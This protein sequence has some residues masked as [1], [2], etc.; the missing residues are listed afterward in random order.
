MDSID[1]I[2]QM[3]RE[4]YNKAADK[5]HILFHNEMNEKEYDRN[6]L[7][8]FSELLGPGASV[9]DAGCGPTGHIGKYLLDKGLKITGVD[10]SDR[11]VELASE[12]NPEIRFIQGDIVDMSFPDESFDGVISYY[13]IV[14]TPKKHLGRIF[15]EFNR[16]LKPRGYLLVAV[17]EGDEEGII[18]D[19]LGVGADIYFSLFNESEIRKYCTGS[20]FELVFIETRNPYDFEI[21]NR[22]IFAI[23]RKC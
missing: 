9:C 4:A 8:S 10:I 19:F 1:S 14:N 13:S 2:H 6:L 3:T 22:R 16:I 15:A 12:N 11:C 17:K 7:D 18:S 20:G 5:Y 23:G 21:N